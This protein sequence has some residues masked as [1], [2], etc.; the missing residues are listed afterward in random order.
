MC[1]LDA[2]RW[3]ASM[4]RELHVMYLCPAF[5]DETNGVVLEMVS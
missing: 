2:R 5:G 3:G 4:T 1:V